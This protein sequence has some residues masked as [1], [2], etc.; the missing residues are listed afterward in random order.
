MHTN[1]NRKAVEVTEI[2]KV[3]GLKNHRWRWRIKKHD[4]PDDSRYIFAAT[5]RQLKIYQI[6]AIILN[7]KLLCTI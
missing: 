7:K 1:V 5:K 4:V 6:Y 3:K 2:E